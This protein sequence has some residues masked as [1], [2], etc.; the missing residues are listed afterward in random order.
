M[1]VREDHPQSAKLFAVW[2]DIRSQDSRWKAGSCPENGSQAKGLATASNEI[3]T[4]PRRKL[5]LLFF[6]H[7][8]EDLTYCVSYN[9][10]A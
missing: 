4:L 5:Y 1:Q 7:E 2:V 10:A 9:I 3:A 6:F 8:H